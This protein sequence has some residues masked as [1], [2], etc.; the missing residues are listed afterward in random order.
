[1]KQSDWDATK[2]FIDAKIIEWRHV[3]KKEY[4]KP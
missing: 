1:M 3:E 4:K 2:D